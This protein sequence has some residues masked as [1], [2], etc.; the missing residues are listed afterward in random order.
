MPHGGCSNSVIAHY[1]AE[2]I[3]VRLAILTG[4]S[5]GSHSRSMLGNLVPRAISN[6]RWYR[7]KVRRLPEAAKAVLPFVL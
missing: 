7:E 2:L 1:L 3:E 6:H 4:R 5:R